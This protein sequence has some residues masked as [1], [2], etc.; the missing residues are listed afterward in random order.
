LFSVYC[1]ETDELYHRLM[2]KYNKYVRPVKN[3]TDI[4]TV[5]FGLKLIQIVDV[6]CIKHL[7]LLYVYKTGVLTR[8]V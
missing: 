3:N 4:V 7:T 6:V 2:S 8:E 1:D 5:K